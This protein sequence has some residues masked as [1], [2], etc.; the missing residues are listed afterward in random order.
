C[1]G[2]VWFA[3]QIFTTTV[4][5]AAA[6]AAVTEPF[7]VRAALWTGGFVG[8]A[9][10]G[11]NLV[12]ALGLFFPALFWVRTR[13]AGGR[14]AFAQS[15]GAFLLPTAVAVA[16]QAAYNHARFGD[17]ATDGLAIQIQT[18]GDPGLLDRWREHGLFDIH[19]LGENL[20]VYLANFRLPRDERG[21]ISYDP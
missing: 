15:F 9:F 8:L 16:L 6:N 10:L 1:S 19:Y 3:A 17:I 18:T 20:R 14:R 7:T 13:D 11:R 2:T 5:L 4:L 12:A 21:R